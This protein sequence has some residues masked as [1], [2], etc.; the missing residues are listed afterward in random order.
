M[1]LTTKATVSIALV[2]TLC[3]TVLAAG[4]GGAGIPNRDGTI[5]ACVV[6]KGKKRGSVRLV[7]SVNACRKHRG[8]RPLS[9]NASGVTAPG[10]PALAGPEGRSG[11]QGER[12][13]QGVVGPAGQIE[14]SLL[15]TIA[16]QKT[17][18]DSLTTQVQTL[19]Q[20]L[21]DLE[22]VVSGVQGGLAGL[23][24]NVGDLEGA[25]GDLETTV[26]DACAQLSAVTSQLDAVS[27]AIGGLSL[28]NA[29]I[30][31]KGALNI[32][33][34]PTPLGGFTCE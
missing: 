9:W 6:A 26:G 14:Q 34:L 22:G 13:I 15:D 4:A 1:K 24:G 20:G 21:G 33:A 5:H 27:T 29:L 17:Q 10:A 2:L 30:L 8:E 32:P 18:I 23:E 19:G 25:V 12:G 28:N 3:C 16:A 7:R 31:L 11:P